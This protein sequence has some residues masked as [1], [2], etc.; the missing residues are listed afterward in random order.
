M[1][2]KIL[3]EAGLPDGVIQFLPGPGPV[4]RARSPVHRA[5][6]S[7]AWANDRAPPPP[8]PA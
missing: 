1:I 2:Y 8:L 3:R 7:S 5:G 4:V 6:A